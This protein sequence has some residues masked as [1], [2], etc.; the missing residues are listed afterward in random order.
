MPSFIDTHA[1]LYDSKYAEDLPEVIAFCLA[2]GVEKIY[3]P[4]LN[5][6]TV[7]PMIAL[8]KEYP[9]LCKAMIG[10]HPCE[11]K[12]DFEDKLAEMATWFDKHIFAAIGEVGTDLYWDKTFYPQQVKALHIA[13]DWA[14]QYNLPLVLHAR[15]SLAETIAIIKERQKGNLTGVFHCFSGTLEEAK[16]IID[17]GFYLGIGGIVTF[18]KS[19]LPALLSTISLNHIVL[20]T[21]SPYLAPTPKRGKRNQPGYLPFITDAIARIKGVSLE[22]VAKKTTENA[23]ILFGAA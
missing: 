20:E 19:H 9:G 4:N 14:E 13:I 6:E 7:A 17:L 3:L 2:Q 16:E 15:E 11:V 8:E 12:E 23:G 22:E 5:L 18:S 10:L 21:D 1:H